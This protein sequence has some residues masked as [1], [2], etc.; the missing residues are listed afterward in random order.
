M[1][2]SLPHRIL[3]AGALIILVLGSGGATAQERSEPDL[4]AIDRYIEDEI[5]ANRVPGLALAITRGDEVLYL[6]GYGAAGDGRPMTPRTRL[7]IAS[8]SNSFTAR[9]VGCRV[10]TL[11]FTRF[12]AY[13][14]DAARRTKSSSPPPRTTR[15]SS[16]R[17][18][19]RA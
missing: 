6:E 11:H 5:A 12:L 16:S 9:N 18:R 17:R 13:S 3:L 1:F 19:G 4:D 10:S 14:Q 15:R 8:L 2:R 7:Y